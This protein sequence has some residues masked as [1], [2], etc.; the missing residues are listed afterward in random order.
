MIERLTPDDIR[1]IHDVALERYGG[2]FGEHES[3]LIDFMADK[4][5][6]E[7]GGVELYPDLFCKAAVYLEGFATH[8]YFCDGN[9]RTGFMCAAL[10]LEINGYRLVVDDDE[11][12]TT[13]KKIANEKMN[14]SQITEWLKEHAYQIH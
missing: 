7:F 6:Q 3:G 1:A 12:Y 9:K 14:L 11:L 5:F 10:F 4:P 2:L 13:V 8:Q